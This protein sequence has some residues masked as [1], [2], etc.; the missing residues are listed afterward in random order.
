MKRIWKSYGEGRPLPGYLLAI[1]SYTALA[2]AVAATGRLTG[3]RL[4]ERF[5]LGD[6]ALVGVATHKASRL[7]TKEAVTSPLRAPFTRYEE[8]A[9][10]AELTES[11]RSDHPA[12]HAIGELLTCPFC[13]GVWIASGLTAGMVFAPRLTRLVSTALA[14]VAASDT[15]NLVYDKL[16]S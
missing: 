3:V 15:L 4:P 2:G 1:G 13:A 12:R 6:T 5:S 9:G 7:L 10:H 14:A 8:P 11:P 16:K